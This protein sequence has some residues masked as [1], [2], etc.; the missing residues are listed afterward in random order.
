MPAVTFRVLILIL[1]LAGASALSPVLRADLGQ[2]LQVIVDRAGE[3]DGTLKGQPY[4]KPYRGG[5]HLAVTRDARDSD[6]P[7]V[8]EILYGGQPLPRDQVAAF[9][10]HNAPEG[11]WREANRQDLQQWRALGW[12]LKAAPAR[13]FVDADNRRLLWLRDKQVIA[14]TREGAGVARDFYLPL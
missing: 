4:W 14:L 6:A 8:F 7:V 1:L 11:D 3:P 2:P 5:I 12:L 13:I 10:A 9:M